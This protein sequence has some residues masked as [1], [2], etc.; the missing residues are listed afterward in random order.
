MRKIL[1]AVAA[2]T[3]A[4]SAGVAQAQEWPAKGLI[5]WIVPYPAGGGTDVLARALGTAL[6]TELKQSF[7]IENRVGA[8]TIVGAEATARS[9]RDGYTIMSADNAT[10][11]NNPAMYT[12]LPYNPDRDLEPVAL[13]GRFPLL[14]VA[15]AKSNI[16]NYAELVALS[17][18][19][20]DKLTY[21][22]SGAGTPF[23]VGMELIKQ[24]THLSARHVPYRGMAPAV[25]DVVSGQVDIMVIDLAT[26]LPFLRDNMLV[27]LATASGKRFEQFPDVPTLVELGALQSEFSAWQGVVVP[28]GTP[29]DI[30]TRLASA[31]TRVMADPVLSD[32]VRALGIE[33]LTSTPE[34]MAAYW[35]KEAD[36]WRPL[37]KAAGITM[38]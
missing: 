13:I 12:K 36:L 31:L 26:A 17:K 1:H 35:H 18:A 25:Q 14:L 27:A 5:R 11:I 2:L 33:P 15:S 29:L 30:R 24:R 9:E 32:R 38:D 28:T 8:A 10:L 22:S 3:L 6:S 34:Q 20:P 21:A 4:L 37:I 16:R 7:V 19:S 23:H